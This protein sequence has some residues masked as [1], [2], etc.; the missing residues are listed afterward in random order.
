LP[1]TSIVVSAAVMPVRAVLSADCRP[2]VYVS[3][4]FGVSC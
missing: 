3:R 4:N 2:M 1:T